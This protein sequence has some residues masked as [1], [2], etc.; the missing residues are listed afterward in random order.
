M[1]A[2][3]GRTPVTEPVIDARPTTCVLR[4]RAAA[5]LAGLFLT[6]VASAVLVLAVDHVLFTRGT[7]S[8][9]RLVPRSAGHDQVSWWQSQVGL[10]PGPT[11]TGSI[12]PPAVVRSRDG[13]NGN[14]APGAPGARL[15][16]GLIEYRMRTD[17]SMIRGGVL[18][19]PDTHAWRVGVDLP[20]GMV[21]ERVHIGLPGLAPLH[22]TLGGWDARIRLLGLVTNSLYVA[23]PLCIVLYFSARTSR[24]GFRRIIGSIRLA[25]GRCPAC[26]YVLVTIN[27]P[28]P[29]CG[30]P[31]RGGLGVEGHASAR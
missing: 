16:D 12:V 27:D 25:R 9:W 30:H 14:G 22:P 1:L 26:A 28:C 7:W 17:S 15:P 19:S 29:E 10:L 23:G 18:V 5:V 3:P 2:D 13:K 6:I 31:A 4:P 21:V 11:T 20:G 24:W 8:G